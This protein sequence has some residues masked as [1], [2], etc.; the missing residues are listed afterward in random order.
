M[1]KIQIRHLKN[2]RND[3]NNL[4]E[5]L[6]SL[7]RFFLSNFQTLQKKFLSRT[8]ILQ[9]NQKIKQNIIIKYTFLK[10]LAELFRLSVKT[11]G[12]LLF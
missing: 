3:F 8:V 2:R 6:K 1:K 11:T 7:T 4:E 9:E 10:D 5:A 12:L